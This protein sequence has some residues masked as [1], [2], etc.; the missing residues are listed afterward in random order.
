MPDELLSRGVIAYVG[1]AGHLPAKPRLESVADVA[2]GRDAELPARVKALVDELYGVGPPL[3]DA[4]TPEEMARRVDAW[5]A[6]NHP[7]LTDAAIRAL[8]NMYTFD[9]K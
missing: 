3:W 4:A 1:K 2:G 6:A 7:E 8:H 9:F 5:L